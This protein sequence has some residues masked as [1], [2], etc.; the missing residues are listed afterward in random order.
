MI[1]VTIIAYYAIV[2]GMFAITAVVEVGVVINLAKF[3]SLLY[4]IFPLK[5]IYIYI[6]I[7]HETF[8]MY[9][10][11]IC[12]VTLNLHMNIKKWIFHTDIR[13]TLRILCHYRKDWLFFY[14]D[15]V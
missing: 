7:Y 12:I 11:Q 9:K 5:C 6:D 4:I 14:C 2:G 15:E 3:Y 10:L 13:S 1:R 8:S